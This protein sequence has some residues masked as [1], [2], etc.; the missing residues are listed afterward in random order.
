MLL[1]EL[2]RWGTRPA[3]VD[4]LLP[5]A[6]RAL[7]WIDEFGDRDGDG[8]VEYERAT[9]KGLENQGWKDSWDA[10]RFADGELAR[11]PIVICEVQAYVYAALRARAHFAAEHGD[12]A[13][14][15][16]LDA[17]AADLKAAFNRDFWLEDRGWYAMGLD[18]DKRPIDA[19]AS[20]VGHCL[21]AGIVDEERAP[22]VADRLLSNEMFSGWGIRTLA[23]SM[24]GYNPLSYHNGSIWPH[25]NAICIAGL[26]RYGLVDAAHRL[27]RGLVASA[28]FTEHRLPELFSGIADDDV[29]FPV[30]YPTSCS[31]QAWAAASPLLLLRSMLRLEPDVRNARVHL[32][33]AVPGWVGRVHVEGI[34]INGGRLSLEV[35]DGALHV[36]EVPG[37]LKIEQ[38][39]RRP[40]A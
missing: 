23:T 36:L 34:P 21:W 22:L 2:A 5:A 30:S 15:R 19:L 6:D 20:N 12:Q 3:E 27:T 40:T 28:A 37:G 17:R 7:A 10:V 13:L 26:M 16:R 8:Y 25:D 24:A 11:S 32:A 31:P 1:G 33:P 38:V 4:A 35:E 18:R 39:P 9:D 14:T 29:P